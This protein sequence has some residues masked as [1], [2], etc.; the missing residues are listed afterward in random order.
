MSESGSQSI[1]SSPDP[2]Q[3]LQETETRRE[4]V[5]ASPQPDVVAKVEPQSIEEPPRPTPRPRPLLRGS[6]MLPDERVVP[7][8][9]AREEEELRKIRVV[10]PRPLDELE[11]PRDIALERLEQEAHF[12]GCGAARRR[13]PDSIRDAAP[14]D[15]MGAL[16]LWIQ[17]RV[18]SPLV[19]LPDVR[20]ERTSIADPVVPQVLEVCSPARG[21][22]R[23]GGSP[24]C[25]L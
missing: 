18:R 23:V 5:L 14:H 4:E 25:H 20:V 19:R 15:P 11:L 24:A 8:V 17:E 21:R 6:R 1:G 2:S 9:Q 3:V 13:R 10:D 7:R 12:A 22:P 16:F